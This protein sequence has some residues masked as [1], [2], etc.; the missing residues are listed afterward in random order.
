MTGTPNSANRTNAAVQLAHWS[1][2][3]PATVASFPSATG[4]QKD[5][6]G[7]TW[8]QVLDELLRIR[9]LEDDWDGEGTEAPAAELVDGAVALA[10]D[11][12]AHDWPAADR[13]IA[14]VNG[15][16]YFEW[17]TPLGYQEIEVMSPTD[18]EY[19]WVRKGSQAAVVAHL[20][21][22]A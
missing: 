16:V 13:V 2:T 22:R 7:L 4:A 18:A 11:L 17:H 6:T 10:Q 19:R 20:T 1:V 9:S 12:A 3:L 21:R 14:G 15:T 5:A 8:R